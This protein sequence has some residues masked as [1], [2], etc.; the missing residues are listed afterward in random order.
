MGVGSTLHMYGLTTS[1]CSFHVHYCDPNLSPNEPLAISTQA[2][3]ERIQ[4]DDTKYPNPR[5]LLEQNYRFAKKEYPL[6]EL[7]GNA[8]YRVM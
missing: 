5:N 6:V 1:H 2:E 4:S 3:A 8:S 7:L